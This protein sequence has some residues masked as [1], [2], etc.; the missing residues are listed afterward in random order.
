[1]HFLPIGQ[2]NLGMFPQEIMKRS[3]PRLL[4][5]RHNEIE[6]LNFVSLP[7]HRRSFYQLGRSCRA[8]ARSYADGCANFLFLVRSCSLLLAAALLP[9]ME[10]GCS[11]IR[12]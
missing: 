8:S 2:C 5:S 4:C 7:E 1:M 11:T 6:A 3:R 12:R 9:M 10:C